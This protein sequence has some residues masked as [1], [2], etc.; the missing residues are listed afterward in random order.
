[1]YCQGTGTDSGFLLPAVQKGGDG[2]QAVLVTT[3]IGSSYPFGAVKFVGRQ[4][5]E[6]HRRVLY[7]DGQ[8]PGDLG[9]VRVEGHAVP[10]GGGAE[11]GDV[12]DGS[13][14]IVCPH[15][16]DEGRLRPD[17]LFQYLRQNPAQGIHVQKR[18]LEAAVHYGA[19]AAQRKGGV[20]IGVNLTVQIA[21]GVQRRVMLRL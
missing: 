17:C 11:S 7:A 14:F 3:E 1:M 9:S 15:Q 2:R 6:V 19:V 20:V 5:H 10:M 8:F 13:D 16:G 18:H 12:I 21:A 4:G